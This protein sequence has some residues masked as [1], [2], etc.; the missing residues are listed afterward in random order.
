M[1]TQTAP[2]AAGFKAQAALVSFKSCQ[3]HTE[4]SLW[5]T[6]KIHAVH[7]EQWQAGTRLSLQYK[8]FSSTEKKK[9]PSKKSDLKFEETC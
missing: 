4:E 5:D 8:V 2:T 3:Q 6:A 7:W 1:Q 9:K